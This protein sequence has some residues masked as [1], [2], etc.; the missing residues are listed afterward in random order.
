MDRPRKFAQPLLTAKRSGGEIF[1]APALSSDGKAIAFLSNGSLA[2]GQ[3]FIDLWL[4]N[5]ETGARIRRLVSSNTSD[6]EELRLL[7]SQSAFSPD[8]TQLAFTGERGGKDL[9]YVMDLKTHEIVKRFDLPIESAVGPSWSPDGAQLVFSGNHG[10][11]TDLYIVTVADGSLQQLTN[12]R[13]AQLMPQWSP[14]GQ[15][16]AFVTDSADGASLAKLHFPKLR[17]ALYRL[18]DHA[19]TVLPVQDGLNIN[20]QWSPDG[21]S[22]AFVSDRT[23]IANVFL[24]DLDAAEHYQLTNVMG[25]VS[26]DR[27]S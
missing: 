24:Y 11:L 6:F 12:D 5:A 4:G 18:A 3:V 27:K 26:A 8:G 9:L 21:R 20:P 15:T 13:F 1:L 22:I 16:I 23:G 10:G 2:R 19:V 7:Y 17:V 25:A 14:D